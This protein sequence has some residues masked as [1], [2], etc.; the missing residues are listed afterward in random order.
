MQV[1]PGPLRRVPHRV[2]RRCHQRLGTLSDGDRGGQLLGADDAGRVCGEVRPM[3]VGQVIPERDPD[4]VARGRE[5][6]HD[7]A[8]L[9]H[10]AE[11]MRG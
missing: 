2:R 11:Q 1:D 8:G 9:G 3:R 5:P 6:D 7:D 10:E 4:A